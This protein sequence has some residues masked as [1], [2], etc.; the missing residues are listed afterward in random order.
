[1]RHPQ[2]KL[3]EMYE[4]TNYDCDT[5]LAMSDHVCAEPVTFSST[6]LVLIDFLQVF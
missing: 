2:E 6:D 1:M 5:G 3:L 4:R